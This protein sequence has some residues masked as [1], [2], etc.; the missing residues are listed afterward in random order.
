MEIPASHA[1]Q[2]VELLVAVGDQVK[3]GD[4]IAHITLAEADTD[5]KDD[6]PATASSSASAEQSSP[7]SAATTDRAAQQPTAPAA[8]AA[9]ADA[10]TQ[11]AAVSSQA[12]ANA[13]D[14]V[15]LGA[16]PGGYSAAFRAADLGLNVVLV[17]RYAT[18]GGVCLNVGCIPSKSLLHTIAAYETALDLKDHGISFE[19]PTI[20]LAQMRQFKDG[21]INKLTQGLAG[22]AKARKVRVIQ[23]V[24]EFQDPHHLSVRTEQGQE[25]VAFKHAII[26]A[27]SRAVHLPFMPDDERVIDSTGAL[28]L[29]EIPEK[30]LVIGGGIIGL[31]MATVYAG[32]GAKIDLVEMQPTLM[33]GADKDLVKI[34]QKHNAWRFENIWLNSKTVSVR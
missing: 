21:V 11:A 15:V 10:T 25:V 6:S 31:E 20:D 16:G 7:S 19:Q 3:T 18:L 9:S 5:A 17:E 8:A 22:M 12:P 29:P 14:L 26:A 34:W 4:A 13:V 24:G 23:G 28:T 2:I 33:Q 32:L 1:G 27:G 30:M